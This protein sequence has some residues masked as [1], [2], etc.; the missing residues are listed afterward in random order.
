M[1]QGNDIV[2]GVECALPPGFLPFHE[3]IS[4]AVN[5]GMQQE[6]PN[7]SHLSLVVNRGP[8][9]PVCA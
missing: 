4:I 9:E 8:A 1:M 7:S 6:G 3:D 2:L 5:R